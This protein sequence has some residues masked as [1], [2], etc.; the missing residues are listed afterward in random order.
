MAEG[1][2]QCEELRQEV[3]KLKRSMDLRRAREREVECK[4]CLTHLANIKA[5][6]EEHQAAVSALKAQ[7]Q[8]ELA[9]VGMLGESSGGPVSSTDGELTELQRRLSLLEEGYE[10]QI[11]ALKHQYEEALGSQPD[12]CEEKVR[13][14]YQLEIEHLRGLC[15]KGLGAMENSHKRMLMEMEEKHCRELAALQAEK[16]QA[17][18]EETQA[19]LAALDA[20][21]KA[22]E[23]EVQR[24]IAKFKEEFIRKMQS[25]H[26]LTA[27]HKEHEAEMEDIRR[28]I[29]SLSQ[30]YSVKCL[31]SAS[32][33]EKLD[34][35]TRQ[36]ADVNKQ[37]F[38]LQARNK[39]LKTHLS[40]QVSQLQAEG[41]RD[42][43]SQL[44]LCE[45]ELG[46][47]KEEVARLTQQLHQTQ[48]NNGGRGSRGAQRR[49]GNSPPLEEHPLRLSTVPART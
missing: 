33:E 1:C 43:E 31:E 21:R 18:A 26:D 17:L 3:A 8:Q 40:A 44:K 13:Q 7:H 36:L 39:Q 5:L 25:S 34:A 30:K 11:T 41:K 22:H 45:A 19:T 38:D 2:R 48:S 42:A 15:E 16:E 14:R 23:S 46:L 32:L 27:I 24:E 10:A 29:L 9:R 47:M 20:M 4:Q 49:E 6:E 35:L 12:L 28:E 37:L